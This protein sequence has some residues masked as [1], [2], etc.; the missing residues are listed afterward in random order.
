MA[1]HWKYLK[2]S[3]MKIVDT[4]EQYKPRTAFA[5][6]ATYDVS[7]HERVLT[8]LELFSK[9]KNIQ[10]NKEECEAL[11]EALKGEGWLI[12]KYQT[13]VDY[14]PYS[15]ISGS[16]DGTKEPGELAIFDDDT[17]TQVN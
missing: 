1:Q 2:S 12:R 11:Q 15:I 10:L 8:K 13:R 6:L 7:L 16:L 9:E 5:V 14:S 17:T 3:D 4:E